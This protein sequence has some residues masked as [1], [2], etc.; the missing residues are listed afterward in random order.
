MKTI[1]DNPALAGLLCFFNERLDRLT[2]R[3]RE[4]RHIKRTVD[5][6]S[7][8]TFMS[9]PA[10]GVTALGEIR[11]DVPDHAVEWP[12]DSRHS[13]AAIRE[14]LIFHGQ[15]IVQTSA[16]THRVVADFKSSAI[17]IDHLP[18]GQIPVLARF[19]RIEIADIKRCIESQRFQ[20][21]SHHGITTGA[22]IIEGEH[23]Q[24]VGDGF[25]QNAAGVGR[26]RR[27]G[28]GDGWEREGGEE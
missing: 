22:C 19:E 1:H 12:A 6:W 21:W 24:F 28:A 7:V 27:L 15:I 26:D 14:Q 13:R 10:E 18:I 9:S 25:A 8:R 3:D 4:R 11:T 23:H 16:M 20:D 5:R 17:Q 2:F